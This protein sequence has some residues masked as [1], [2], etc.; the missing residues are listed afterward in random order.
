MVT[1]V[2]FVV[3]R[4]MVTRV[5]FAVPGCM[6]VRLAFIVPS[7]MSACGAVVAFAGL[8]ARV[9]RVAVRVPVALIGFVERGQIVAL[10]GLVKPVEAF[11]FARF[12][13]LARLAPSAA[14]WRAAQHAQRGSL[15]APRRHFRGSLRMLRQLRLDRRAAPRG[16]FAVDKR[17][18]RS[19]IEP[20]GQAGI[21]VVV[22]HHGF[23]TT[24]NG[25]ALRAAS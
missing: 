9:E 13:T 10:A 12:I 5:A 1:R 17:R 20:I 3:A 19:Q 6:S 22:I 15:R 7:C 16:Q 21:V 2:A 23:L 4:G 11:A 25:A 24:F 18:Q 8:A 14:P